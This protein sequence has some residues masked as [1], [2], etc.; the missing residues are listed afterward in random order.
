MIVVVLFNPGHSVVML[1]DILSLSKVE[2][3]QKIF[4][5]V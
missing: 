3:V 1:E 4:A 2:F 5:A